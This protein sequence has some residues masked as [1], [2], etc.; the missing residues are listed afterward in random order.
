[1]RACTPLTLLMT[2]LSSQSV[3]SLKVFRPK[4][5]ISRFAVPFALVVINTFMSSSISE[6][7][8]NTQATLFLSRCNF[9]RHTYE[10][11]SKLLILSALASTKMEFDAEYPGTAVQRLNSVHERVKSL[12]PAQLNG[13]WS[14]VR[15]KLLWAG[16]GSC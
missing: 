3:H 10:L 8:G 2:L 4:R 15:R 13:D 5:S 12:T 7:T 9:F 1:M 16:T 14:S 11:R 6:G